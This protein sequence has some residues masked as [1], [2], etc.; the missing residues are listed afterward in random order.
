M[1]LV[2]E[3]KGDYVI[4]DFLGRQVSIELLKVCEIVDEFVTTFQS[5]DAPIFSLQ[6]LFV[7]VTCMF[8]IISKTFP[9][10]SCV[11]LQTQHSTACSAK[12]RGTPG[13]A[14]ATASINVSYST[15]DLL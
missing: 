14:L 13:Y 3:Q 9:G 4:C 2:V 10:Q 15:F 11:H 7:G 8:F 5:K 1:A 12:P 6:P